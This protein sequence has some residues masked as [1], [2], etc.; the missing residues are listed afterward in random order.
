MAKTRQKSGSTGARGKS[1]LER[2]LAAFVTE[3]YPLAAP[4]VL[5]ALSDLLAPLPGDSAAI[6]ALRAAAR[7][8]LQSAVVAP[9]SLP[10]TNESMFDVKNSIKPMIE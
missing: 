9:I 6:D 5:K 3:R 2:R 1:A 8:A 4:R 7:D 10:T